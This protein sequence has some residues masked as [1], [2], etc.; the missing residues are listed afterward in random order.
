MDLAVK[1]TGAQ[2]C[3][4]QNIRTVGGCQNNNTLR[5]GET[6]HFYQQLV[7][8]LFLF[9]M[10]AAEAAAAL[11]AHSIDL[12]DEDNGRSDFLG[13]LEQ[14]TDAACADTNIHFYEVR[15][16]NGQ[17]L[18]IRLTCNCPGQQGLTGAGGTHQQ[19]TVGNPGADFSKLL[20]ILQ[21]IH[22]FLQFFLLLVR[23]GNIRKC[24]LL[25]VRNTQNGAGLA[26]VV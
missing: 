10:A 25:A 6:V 19:H 24:H 22:D 17:E 4:V 1:T 7:Q 9:V 15:A 2:Q 8:G 21:E 13:L 23:T 20:G 5:T 18:Y 14:I 3:G 26:E 16:G 12:I 11:A